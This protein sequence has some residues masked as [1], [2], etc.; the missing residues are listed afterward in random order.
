MDRTTKILL[1]AIAIGLWVNTAAM[2]FRPL[3]AHAQDVDLS[4]I[5][6]AVEAIANGVCVNSKIC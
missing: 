1:T 2:L 4:T 3:S 5:E 6:N